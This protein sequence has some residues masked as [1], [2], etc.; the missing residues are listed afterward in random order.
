M[1]LNESFNNGQKLLGETH[2]FLECKKVKYPISTFGFL[3]RGD[4][5]TISSLLLSL[6]LTS[7]SSAMFTDADKFLADVVIELA[8]LPNLASSAISD[9]KFW[10]DLVIVV[11]SIEVSGPANLFKP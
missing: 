10:A 6:L 2:L 1:P 3:E 4:L 9:G 11:L 7:A 5:L 8:P